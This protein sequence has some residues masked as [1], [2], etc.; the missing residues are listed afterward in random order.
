MNVRDSTFEVMRRLGMTRIFGNP[1]STEVAFLTDL[2]SDLEFVLGLHE[3]SVVGMATGYAIGR[4]KPAF[5]NLHTAPGLGNAINAIANARD[6]HAPLVVVVGQ[7]D[8]R[9]LASS[10]FLA[11]RGLERVA[12]EYPV[13]TSLPVRPQ[14]VPGAIARAYHEAL[15]HR[16]PALVVAPM[17]DWEQEADPLAIGAPGQMLRPS[18]VDPAE[19]SELAELIGAARDPVLVVGAGAASDAGW[20]SVTVLAESLGSPVWQEAFGSRPGFPQTHQ[21]F[22][23]HLP[24]MR[25]RMRERLAPHDLVIAVGTHALRTY[26]FDADVALLEPSTRVAV[27]SDDADEVHRSGCDIGVL[28]P[29]AETCAALVAQ[30]PARGKTPEAPL[31][32]A[33]APPDPPGPGAK[34]RPGHV[35][36]ALAERLPEDVVLVEE[37]PSSRPELLERIPAHT[38][39]GFVANANGGLG[40]GL[41]G[42]IGLRMALPDR[43]VVAV[44]GDGSAIYAIQSLWSAARYG[45]GALLIVMNNG[46]YAI[47]DA[48]A[49]ARGGSAPWPGFPGIDFVGI[50]KALGCDAVRISD[51]ETLIATLDGVLPALAARENPILVE[52]ELEA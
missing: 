14:D 19:L 43:P 20:A 45:A 32:E 28:A 27:I 38:P 39:L 35:L 23:G 25:A 30:L 29:V 7:Q 51:H 17:G 3:G 42:T 12:G 48:Q 44:V 9:Q 37:T 46:G 49:R 10:P 5:V 21:L 6:C 13:W 26:V 33:P 41:S 47:M 31:H 15:T 18:A 1:G 11:G 40:F 50:A 52:V 34:L 22:A 16:G 24:W 36:A 4:R 8:R 2:P